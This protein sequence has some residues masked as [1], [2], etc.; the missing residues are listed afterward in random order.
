MHDKGTVQEHLPRVRRLSH[1]YMHA[2]TVHHTHTHTHT[3]THTH[4][5]THTH[6]PQ[7]HTLLIAVA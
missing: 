1:V 7:V 5:H 2:R 6:T 4:T 3:Y